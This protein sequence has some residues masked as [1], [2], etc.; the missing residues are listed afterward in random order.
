MGILNVTFGYFFPQSLSAIVLSVYIATGNI[1]DLGTAYTASIIF[2]MIEDPLRSVPDFVSQY[3]E[4]LISMRRI[5]EFLLCQEVNKTLVV[6]QEEETTLNA[7]E[8]N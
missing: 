6:Q 5:Q 7:I 8:I 1:L 3:V 2:M 4:L